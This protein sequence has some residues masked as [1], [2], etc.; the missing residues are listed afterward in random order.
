MHGTFEPIPRPPDLFHAQ[1]PSRHPPRRSFATIRSAHSA[2]M[3][4]RRHARTREAHSTQTARSNSTRH[5]R[6]R[7]SDLHGQIHVSIASRHGRTRACATISAACTSEP[8]AAAAV[9][10]SGA[11]IA[12]TI[13]GGTREPTGRRTGPRGFALSQPRCRLVPAFDRPGSVPS[14]ATTSRRLRP[15]AGRGSAACPDDRSAR[16]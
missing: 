2:G 14:C 3:P 16:R 1:A 5:V 10:G 8:A 6:T 11:E 12:R 9:A 15:A 4:C 13:S 7:P